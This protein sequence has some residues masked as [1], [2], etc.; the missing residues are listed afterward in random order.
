MLPRH[1]FRTYPKYGGFTGQM[2]ETNGT[3]STAIEEDPSETS[4]RHETLVGVSSNPGKG[5]SEVSI[6]KSPG[7]AKGKT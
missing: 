2:I 7:G 6:P 5:E 4:N 1:Q 3:F